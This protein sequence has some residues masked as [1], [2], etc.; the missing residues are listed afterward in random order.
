MY[1]PLKIEKRDGQYVW[2]SSFSERELH[3]RIP[4]A[5]FSKKDGK[6]RCPA[7][8]AQWFAFKIV[9]GPERTEDMPEYEGEYVHPSVGELD[10]RLRDYQERDVHWLCS[11]E[12]ALLG[13]DVG[14]GKTPITL[15]ALS[16]FKGP[17]LVVCPNS[18]KYNWAKEAERW[19][20]FTPYVVDGTAKQR[21]DALAAAS[22]DP[23]N[24][25]VVINYEAVRLHSRLE[26][27]GYLKLSEV[28]KEP[29]ELNAINFDTVVC[30]EAHA[31]TDPKSKKTRAVKAVARDAYRRWALTGTPISNRVGGLWSII[32]FID[33]EQAGSRSAFEDLWLD[34]SPAFR[35]KGRVYHGFNRTTRDSFDSWMGEIYIARKAVDHLPELGEL[36][37]PQVLE[38]PMTKKQA[39]AYKTLAE[40][41]VA[42]GE[43]AEQ[44]YL[45]PNELALL[46]GLRQAANAVPEVVDGAIVA[47]TSDSN[48]L[49]ALQD[50]LET[51]DDPLVVFA[52][53]RRLLEMFERELGKTYDIGMVTG[54]QS[55]LDR[56]KAVDRFQDGLLDL[57][58]VTYAAGGEGLTLTR[59]NRIVHADLS[60][61]H[62]KVHQS[63]G[64]LHRI[65]QERPV[66]PI[67]FESVFPD[68]RPTVDLAVR[69]T[70]EAKG[71]TSADFFRIGAKGALAFGGAA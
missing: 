24:A 49:G 41:F 52:E 65:G 11:K 9:F 25:L 28:E 36:M 54:G 67:V 64:R 16:Q 22:E 70:V 29:K 2:E 33:R 17:H 23:D 40:E 66:L 20:D 14:L 31:L 26:G 63:R 62:A 12:G 44:D 8:A 43:D 46:Q 21:R 51:A 47:A 4:G 19:S 10:E 60:W 7:R 71:E 37:E 50:L 3:R 32:D 53:S 61:S 15:Q 59:A 39:A 56:Q 55:A 42:L 27:Y 30:D 68:G 34:T 57:I 35:G 5:R 48:K 1:A 45:A 58:L 13:H 69:K 18:L 38:L 6:W